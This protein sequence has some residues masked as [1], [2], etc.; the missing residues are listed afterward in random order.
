MAES[1]RSAS[2]LFLPDKSQAGGPSR[3]GRKDFLNPVLC[4]FGRSRPEQGH[5][6]EQ[7][8]PCKTVEARNI[9]LDIHQ[10]PDKRDDELLSYTRGCDVYS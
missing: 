2:V 4:G 9:N 5:R 8:D 10:H 1:I 6:T 3:T 7:E